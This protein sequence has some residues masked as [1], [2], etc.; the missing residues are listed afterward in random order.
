MGVYENLKENISVR[1]QENGNEASKKMLELD[2]IKAVK[3]LHRDKI[4]NKKIA[5]ALQDEYEPDF[6]WYTANKPLNFFKGRKLPKNAIEKGNRVIYPTVAR[7]T[8]KMVKECIEKPIPRKARTKKK[9]LTK[10]E[11]HFMDRLTKQ[12]VNKDYLEHLEK[13]NDVEIQDF[14]DFM[15]LSNYKQDQILKAKKLK[16]SEYKEELYSDYKEYQKVKNIVSLTEIRES[17][18][19]EAQRNADK[20]ELERIEEKIAKLGLPEVDTGRE[21]ALRLGALM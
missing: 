3:K 19:N 8:S 11:E 9:E 1:K 5:Q 7:F 21:L 4:S 12:K 17:K 20:A 15:K 14:N 18:K 13:E 16:R 10:Q 6:T 2:V